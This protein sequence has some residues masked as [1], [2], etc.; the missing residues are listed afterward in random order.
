MEDPFYLL[1]H[2]TYFN[3]DIFTEKARLRSKDLEAYHIFSAQCTL[4][5]TLKQFTQ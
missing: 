5:F 4:Q 1:F 2:L 3:D